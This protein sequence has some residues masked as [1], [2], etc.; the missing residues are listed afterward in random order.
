VIPASREPVLTWNVAG[1]LGEPAGS[2]REDVVT[3]AVPDLGDDRRLVVPVEGTLRLD[4]TN[5]G[6]LVRA[7]LTAALEMECSR[8][9]R[10]IVVPL[11]LA[12][13][14]EVLPSIDLRSGVP[15]DPGS[16]PDAVRLTDHHELELE[17]LVV[18]A[19]DL[20]EP[21]APT[22]RPDCPG[23]CSVC[24]VPHEDGAHDHPDEDVD[25]RL[26][27][28]RAFRVDAGPASE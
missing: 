8:C 6:V 27:A 7:D 11:E 25:P 26:A 1:L 21:I 16:E 5:R 4:R 2:T 28:L 12:I 9:L 10:S 15:V 20:A 24:G 23:L 17:R 3:R 22:C 14:E 13:E 19:I 18:E